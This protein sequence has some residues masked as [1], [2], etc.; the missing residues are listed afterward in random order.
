MVV[1]FERYVE[2]SEFVNDHRNER[3]TSRCVSDDISN[4]Q[5]LG[6]N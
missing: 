2:K 6:N 4:V 3:I 5:T 1:D